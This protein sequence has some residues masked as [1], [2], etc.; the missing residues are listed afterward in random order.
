M[1][2]ASIPFGPSAPD[3][4]VDPARPLPRR[5]F[6]VREADAAPGTVPTMRRFAAE[7]ARRW[8][9]PA[10]AVDRLALVVS[11][12][13]TNVVQH[14][15]S[16]DVLVAIEFDGSVLTVEV[17]DSGMWRSRW[18]ARHIPEDAA[19]GGLGLEL[20]RHVSTWWLAF[21]SPSGTRV[22]ASLTVAPGAHGP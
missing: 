12:L 5:E 16:V 20:V 8:N 10:E 1:A 14:S 15:H 22:V 4:A 9:V 6:A 11:E 7:A 21:P 2:I 19:T 3:R 18:S 13:V 17:K